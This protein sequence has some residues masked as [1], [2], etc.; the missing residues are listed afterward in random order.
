MLNVSALASLSLF[1]CG[2]RY[3][4]FAPLTLN[5]MTPAFAWRLHS[6]RARD[7]ANAGNEQ[8]TCMYVSSLPLFLSSFHRRVRSSVFTADPVMLNF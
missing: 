4:E 8:R 2:L 3:R 1:F 7:V 6:K 5:T